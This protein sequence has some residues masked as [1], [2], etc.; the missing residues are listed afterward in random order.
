MER[1]NPDYRRWLKGVAQRLGLRAF[2]RW[3]VAELTPLMP[4][5]VRT[6]LRRRR[7]HPIVVVDRDSALLRAPRIANGT[8][9]FDDVAF[10]PLQGDPAEVAREG[11]AAIAALPRTNGAAAAETNV[12]I[13]LPANQVLRKSVTLPAAVEENLHQTLAYDLDRHTPFKTDEVY[14]DAVV[15]GRDTAKKEIRVH[16]AAALKSFVDQARRRVEAWGARVVAVTPDA[17]SPATAVA[18]TSLNLL[19]PAERPETSRW[20]QWQT[21]VPIVAIAIAALLVIALPIW[22]KRTQAILLAQLVD[23]ARVQADASAALRDELE[24]L[25]GDYNFALQRKYAF[26]AAMQVVEDV[27]RLLP[28]DTWL[29]QLEVKTTARG[30]DAR[31]EIV[32]RGESANAGRLVSLL[33]DSKVFEQAAPRSPT[34]KIQ[35]G[36]GEIFDLGA[37]LKSLA[38]PHSLQLAEMAPRPPPAKPTPAPPAVAAAPGPGGK[39]A[40]SAPA[41]KDT[42]AASA[43]KAKPGEPAPAPGARASGNAPGN[44][45]PN[46]PANA[47]PARGGPPVQPPAQG[48]AFAPVQPAAQVPPQAPPVA[49]FAAPSAEEGADQAEPRPEGQ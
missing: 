12:V 11:H 15:V 13:A 38:L 4:A 10:I 30:K 8:V 34:T 42:D 1:A 6:A 25:T 22:Q 33:E 36:P 44:A 41:A 14:F 17:L 47:P 18:A 32:L 29:T 28:D 37:Q 9:A 5:R 48:P 31:R 39:P 46:A 7:L 23:H 26:P 21:W 35:P 16:L 2:W 19:P 49:P 3:W 45:V 27:T 40:D 43:M 20:R 24:R